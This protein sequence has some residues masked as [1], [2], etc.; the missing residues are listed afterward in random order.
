MKNKK[1]KKIL[2]AKRAEAFSIIFTLII[3][4]FAISFLIADV[5]KPVSAATSVTTCCEKTKFGE[6]CQNTLPENCNSAFQSTPTSCDATSF[7][8]TGCCYSSIEGICD[9][10]TPKK[11]CES[12][13][14]TWTA[15]ANCDIPQCQLGCCVLFNQASLETLVRCKKLS[16]DL[17][18]NTDWRKDISDEIICAQTYQLKDVGACVYEQDF[19]KTCKFTS[20]ED[21]LKI[22]ANPDDFHKD[23]LCSAEELGTTCGPSDETTCVEGKDEVYFID[24]CGNPANIYDASKRNDIDYWKKVVSKEDSCGAG[25]SNAKSTSCGNCGYTSGSVCSAWKRGLGTA[26]KY[27]DNI[28]SDLNCYDTSNGK[29]YL[30][31]ESWC[32]YDE[33]IKNGSALA[34]SRYWRHLCIEGEEKVEPCGDFRQEVCIENTIKN[35]GVDFSF[36]KCRLNNWRGCLGLN[37]NECA[38][39]PED[40]FFM[41]S[42]TFNSTAKESESQ[43]Y[44]GAILSPFTSLMGSGKDS[45]I[46]KGGACMPIY[47]AGLKA[48]E[49][50]EICATANSRCDVVY[51]KG[52]IASDWKCVQNCE[53]LTDAWVQERNA[54][55][56]ALGDC[57]GKKNIIGVYTDDGYG[58]KGPG[59]NKELVS[60]KI[61]TTQT[62]KTTT[63]TQPRNASQVTGN[64]VA[65]ISGM[66]ISTKEACEGAGGSCNSL[67]CPPTSDLNGNCGGYFTPQNCCVPK[68]TD[69]TIETKPEAKTEEQLKA[70]QDA[71]TKKAEEE[72]KAAAKAELEKAVSK[73]K[74]TD[75]EKK[76]FLDETK[77]AET[78]DYTKL[79]SSVGSGMVMNKVLDAFK[80]KTLDK[81]LPT[82]AAGAAGTDFISTT[83]NKFYGVQ[84]R[85]SI[86]GMPVVWSFV[87]YM[88]GGMLGGNGKDALTAA[89]FY[90]TMTYRLMMESAIKKQ[91]ALGMNRQGAI[92]AV[93]GGKAAMWGIGVGLVIFVLTYKKN[94]VE[95]VT[96]TCGQWQAPVGGADCEKCNKDDM[97]PCSEYRCSSL[98]QNCKILNPGN[99]GNET[100]VNIN[101]ND[102]KA[103]L[104]TPWTNVLAK[105]YSYKNVKPCPPGPGCWKVNYDKDAQGCVVA[106]SQLTFG[107]VTDEP[108]QC[109]YDY[110]RTTFEQMTYTMENGLYVY[111]HSLIFRKPGPKN[112]NDSGIDSA[113]F[114]KDGNYNLYFICRDGSGNKNEGQLAVNFCVQKGPD[115]TPPRIE[116]TLI[117]TNAGVSFGAKSAVIAIYLNEPAECK[118][119]KTDQ[120]F[121]DMNSSMQCVGT[122]EQ[123]ESDDTYLCMAN[124]T[125]L[126]DKVDNTFYFNCKDQPW[127]GEAEGRNSMTPNY[128]FV[129]KGTIPLNITDIEPNNTIIYGNSEPIPVT[130]KVETVNGYDN[131]K[132]VC[133]YSPNRNSGFIEFFETNSE[134]HEQTLNLNAGQYKYYISCRDLAGNVDLSSTD[135]TLQVDDASPRVVRAYRETSTL[136]IITDEESV[137]VYDIKSCNY[138]FDSGTIMPYSGS[139]EH[140]ADWRTDITYYIKCKDG[141]GNMPAPASCSLVAH[142]YEIQTA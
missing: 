48:G 133:S 3:S 116:R 35:D 19:Q 34:G 30:H 61:E 59:I 131:G 42:V 112:I 14:G 82:K 40:C 54:V 111:N 45:Y 15:G 113:E 32:V 128:K 117:E 118:W 33:K 124:L 29:D 53:C 9:K 47:P 125:G 75:A 4:I 100:C 84:S 64:V 13:N 72:K 58:V 93:S 108:A 91:M 26:P 38:K 78:G 102:A 68:K 115:T 65:G 73:T 106:S 55:C 123:K 25:K 81:I 17:G 86:V 90:G 69:T 87:A 76:Q 60:K 41:G 8:K 101:P 43:G 96:F 7:C 71:A 1:L 11:L 80:S 36:A 12:N 46:T 99:I 98:G 134:I 37:E 109:K 126:Q 135:F 110:N 85:L 57:G 129:L 70:E 28:C 130:L 51:E 52:L 105:D 27:G 21:C 67:P 16:A 62:T 18:Y 66:A 107:V 24:T 140:S 138:E 103:P 31:G 56:N 95:T 136:K 23:I 79:I 132:S 119:S 89:T 22:N 141:F 127:L 50:S 92:N 137:C 77:N 122:Y 10:N 63:I 139:T 121:K 44:F 6:W 39:Y 114:N 83:W 74:W 20:R 94:K 120:S 97:K 88:V 142:G 5:S 49:S 2:N 104:L